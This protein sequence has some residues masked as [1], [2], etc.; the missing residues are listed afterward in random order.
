MS[1]EVPPSSIPVPAEH[2]AVNKVNEDQAGRS[3]SSDNDQLIKVLQSGFSDLIRKQDEIQKAV[4]ALKPPVPVA[5]KKSTFWTSYMKLADEHDKEFKEKYGTDLDTALIF[6]GLFS[7]IGSAFIIQ[8]E[9]QLTGAPS[10]KIIVAESLLYISLSTTLLVALLAVL[11]KQWLMYYQAAGSGGTIEE[12]G[13]QRQRKFDG[14][15]KWKFDTVMQTLPLLLQLALL[16]FSIALSVYLWT[17]NIPIAIIVL[18]FT[19]TLHFKPH[20]LHFSNA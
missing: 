15:H 4:E 1:H 13:L 5:D 20:L 18:T 9:P 8:I 3:S 17:V 11:G 16:L 14:L 6:A 19:S 10:A 7:A 2:T 12:R